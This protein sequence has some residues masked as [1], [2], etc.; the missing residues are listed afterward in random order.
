MLMFKTIATMAERLN[1]VTH[2][3][4][5]ASE[6]YKKVVVGDQKSTIRGRNRDAVS[7]ACLFIACQENS[8]RDRRTLKE[9][10]TVANGATKK[11]IGHEIAKIENQ[12]KA[13]LGVGLEKEVAHAGN[14]VTRFCHKI[15]MTMQAIKATQEAVQKSEELD[16][17]RNPASV[18]AAVMFMI[19]RLSKIDD[20]KKLLGDISLAAGVAENT[21]RNA[22]KDIH[23]HA[24]RLI[25]DWYAKCV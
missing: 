21:I 11:S 2:I 14:Y 13:E 15:G 12:M 6:I 10:S 3:K 18:A 5:R 23:P 20:E 4:D 17:R 1:L 8:S 16:I 9:I 25:P 22:C 19:A 24:S 7:A